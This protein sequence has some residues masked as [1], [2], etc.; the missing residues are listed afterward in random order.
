MSLTLLIMKSLFAAKQRIYFLYVIES[1]NF[2]SKGLTTEIF[3]CSLIKLQLL[4]D[5][6]CETDGFP[7]LGRFRCEPFNDVYGNFRF[8]LCQV[9]LDSSKI[10]SLLDNLS[11]NFLYLLKKVF[12]NFQGADTAQLSG[13]LP[14]LLTPTSWVR[15]P[16]S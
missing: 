2:R 10:Y 4:N 9:F 7:Q 8:R 11:Y 1:T 15:L 12:H 5:L 3:P 13:R 16:G 6:T 14:E